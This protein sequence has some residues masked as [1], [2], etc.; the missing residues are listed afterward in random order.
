M[1]RRFTGSGLKNCFSAFL[2]MKVV[3]LEDNSYAR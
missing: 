3:K 2:I 1:E